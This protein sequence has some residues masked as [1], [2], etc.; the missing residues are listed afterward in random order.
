MKRIKLRFLALLL[1]GIGITSLN[2]QN[3]TVSAGGDASGN[4]GSVAYS[5][6]QVLYAFN[7]GE[8]GT[9]LHGIQQP[10]EIYTV[11]VENLDLNV[12]MSVFPNPTFSQL[13]LEVNDHKVENMHY[14]L[15][16][17]EGRLI[18][19]ADMTEVQT[20]INLQ[21]QHAGSYYLM[22]TLDQKPLQTFKIIKNN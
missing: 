16:T 15:F 3:A 17:T 19:N 12:S 13:I 8:T 2:A 6:G 20:L 14:H 5:I 22:V 9:V 11:G 21:S 10:Y 4:G 7:S 18:E 1:F